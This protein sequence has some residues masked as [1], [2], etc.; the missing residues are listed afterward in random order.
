[1]NLHSWL[2]QALVLLASL[3]G[4]AG[5][6]VFQAAS[7]RMGPGLLGFVREPRVVLGMSCCVAVMALT[8]L[9][10]KRGGT[11]ATLCP[12]YALTFLWTA[13]WGRV[14]HAELLRPTQLAGLALL[15]TGIA[16]TQSGR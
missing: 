8:T 14:A 11:V 9:A 4:A 3:L 15:V 16:L 12:V 2:P 6:F 13:A 7:E 1:M 5:Q 10:F